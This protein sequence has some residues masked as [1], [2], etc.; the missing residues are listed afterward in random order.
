MQFTG[1]NIYAV[2]LAAVVGF[3]FG[4]L[5]YGVLFPKQWQAAAGKSEADMK[6]EGPN[7][8]ALRHRVRRAS[9]HGVGAGRHHRTSRTCAGH[10]DGK[11]FCGG[12]GLAWGS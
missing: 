1:L 9:R 11:P 4:W 3:M 8:D 12:A 7:R 6:A 2:V 10:L 5:W